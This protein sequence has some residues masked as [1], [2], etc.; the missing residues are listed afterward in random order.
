[1][2][3]VQISMTVFEVSF[4]NHSFEEWRIHQFFSRVNVQNIW[5]ANIDIWL[6]VQKTHMY[7][8]VYPYILSKK[9]S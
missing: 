5:N 9:E 8:Y 4:M 7:I 3:F 1:M 6:Y 2:I